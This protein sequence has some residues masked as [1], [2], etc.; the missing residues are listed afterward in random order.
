MADVKNEL[1]IVRLLD[2]PRAKVWRA[3]R[4]VDALK[5]WWGL[6]K[7]ATMPTCKL[8]FRI[9]GSMLCEIEPSNGERIWFVWIYREIVDGERLVLE[10]H[11]SDTDW[12]ELD[13]PDRP[14]SLVT[15]TLEEA[16]GKT[17]LTVTHAGMAS[18]K[19]RVED[20]KAGWSQSLD[21]LDQH[22]T[23]AAQ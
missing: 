10:Q 20:F 17:R 13:T 7:G 12:R 2:A 14:A 9:G 19:Y 4:E 15:V 3:L 11:A 16:D 18:A 1:T 8:D 23:G 21:Q 22:L 5:Q 6:P